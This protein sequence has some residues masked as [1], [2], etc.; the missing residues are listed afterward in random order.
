RLDPGEAKGTVGNMHRLP[1][2]LW[3]A[4]GAGHSV[5]GSLLGGVA[6][7]TEVDRLAVA[8]EA[9]RVDAVCRKASQLARAPAVDGNDLQ[10]TLLT[11]FE[12]VSERLSVGSD[13]VLRRAF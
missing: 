8:A 12:H 10:H 7:H 13:S 11:H 9:Q 3:F 4:A 5:R 6:T 1:H 2:D